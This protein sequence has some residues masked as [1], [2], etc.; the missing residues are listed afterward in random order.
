MSQLLTASGQLPLAG[1]RILVTAPRN[2]ASRLS[3]EIICQGGLPI[4]M[5]TIETC[6]LSDYSQLDAILNHIDEFDWIAFTSR[7]GIIAFFERLHDLNISISQLQNC[8]L[9]A[10]GKDVEILQSL[11]GRVDLLPAESSPTGIINE[12]SQIQDIQGQ[13]ILVPIPEVIGIPEPDVVPK[14]IAGLKKLDMQVTPVS[15]YITQALDKNIYPVELNLIRQGYIDVIA[16]SSTA[17]IESFITMFNADNEFKNCVIA[18]FGPYT[19]ANAKKLGL[20]VSIVSEDFSSFAGF[21]RAMVKF[22]ANN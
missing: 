3:A 2:Y 1:K 18:C 15:T 13:K 9:S 20:N 21:V 17:E 7:N 8:Q 22:Y 5:P 16:F 10:L 19:A 11:C 6:Y 4:F 12:L 14:F